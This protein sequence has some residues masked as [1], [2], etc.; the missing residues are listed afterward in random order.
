MNCS[1]HKADIPDF[2]AMVKQLN[3]HKLKSAQGT[4]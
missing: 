2:N 3:T 4:N 1:L